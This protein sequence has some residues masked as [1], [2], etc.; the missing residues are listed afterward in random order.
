MSRPARPLIS[1]ITPVLN[2][3]AGLDA[4][5][6]RV[7]RVMDAPDAGA[8]FEIVFTD[9][10]SADTTFAKIGELA[11]KDARISGHR[12]ARNFGYQRS[13]WTGYALA[14]GD[15]VIELDADL[16]DPPELIPRFVAR[17]RE[18]ADIVYGVRERREEPKSTEFLRKVYYRLIRALSDDDLPNDAGDF[19]LLDRRIVDHIKATYDP[20]IYIRGVVFSLGFERAAIAYDRSARTVGASKFPLSRM[21]RLGLDGIIRHSTMPLRL[22]SFVGIAFSVFA[23]AMAAFYLLLALIP[24]V[25]LPSGFTTIVLLQLASLGV[26][27]TL[28]GIIGEYLARMY[29]H[30]RGEPMTIIDAS[31]GT[32]AANALQKAR[33]ARKPRP[34]PRKS[35]SE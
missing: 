34:A 3:E 23:F 10:R 1:I 25:E 27:A 35:E 17:W 22:A 15:A 19:M 26:T 29:Q 21:V 18:G 12:F 4:Y 8:D 9:N 11:R 32:P 13:I 33:G 2:E 24:G 7:A 6:A 31:T 20:N 5:Y 28:L 16:Q 30:Q 14:K